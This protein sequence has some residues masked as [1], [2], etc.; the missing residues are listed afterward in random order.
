MES[1]IPD[2]QAAIADLDTAVVDVVAVYFSNPSGGETQISGYYLR[3]PSL[4]A[5]MPWYQSSGLES[6]TGWVIWYDSGS[7]VWILSLSIATQDPASDYWWQ[8]PT[9]SISGNYVA[10]GLATHGIGVAAR[11]DAG[12]DEIRADLNA[13]HAVLRAAGLIST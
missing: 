8:S 2:R 7:A 4:Y 3:Q 9:S 13:I 1:M 12:R 6:G 10:N 5:G 11:S